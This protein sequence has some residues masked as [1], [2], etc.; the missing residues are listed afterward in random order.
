MSFRLPVQP[1]LQDSIGI[2]RRPIGRPTPLHAHTF[3]QKKVLPLKPVM[4]FMLCYLSQWCNQPW[5]SALF[6]WKKCGDAGH[7]LCNELSQ[8]VAW[9]CYILV[10]CLGSIFQM[11]WVCCCSNSLWSSYQHICSLGVPAGCPIECQN[12]SQTGAQGTPD[13]VGGVPL[14]KKKKSELIWQK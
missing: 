3:L 9:S 8:F 14:S 6:P 4:G 13:P 5:I 10:F 1:Y 12:N 11:L 2:L 7:I